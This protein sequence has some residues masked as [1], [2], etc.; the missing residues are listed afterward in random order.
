M[1]PGNGCYDLYSYD[2]EYRY[3]GTL[4]YNESDDKIIV[5]D[6]ISDETVEFE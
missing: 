2:D 1:N 6:I 5:T 3:V 4:V